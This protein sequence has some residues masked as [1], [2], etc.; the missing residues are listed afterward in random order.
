V[1][2]HNTSRRSSDPDSRSR[3]SRARRMLRHMTSTSSPTNVPA[4]GAHDREAVGGQQ[5]TL[6]DLVDLSLLAKRGR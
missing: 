4:I 5:T 2:R 1:T 3:R 6:V